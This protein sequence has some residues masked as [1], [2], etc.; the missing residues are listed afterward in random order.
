MR[1]A[2]SRALNYRIKKNM[3]KEG[4]VFLSLQLSDFLKIKEPFCLSLFLSLFFF[5]LSFF[6]FPFCLITSPIFPSSSLSYYL[7]FSSFPSFSFH[8]SLFLL[9]EC[10]CPLPSPP[11]QGHFVTVTECV[12]CGPSDPTFHDGCGAPVIHTKHKKIIVSGSVGSLYHH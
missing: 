7:F 8:S 11:D 3:D 12:C 1:T 6:F 2:V 4:G 9:V 5:L 10:P